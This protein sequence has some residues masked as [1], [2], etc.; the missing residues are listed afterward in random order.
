MQTFFWIFFATIL[1]SLAA[2]VGIFTLSLKQKFLDKILLRLVALSSGAMLGGAFIYLLPEGVGT[3]EPKVFSLF[4]LAA[5]ILYFLIE[6]ILHW[7]HCHNGKHCAV[8]SFGYLN[9][10]GGAV[11][12]FIDGLIIAAA[13]LI[14]LPLG[15]TTTLAIALHVIP[16]EIGNFAILLYAGLNKRKA[17]Y[18]NFLASATIILGGITGL[19]LSSQVS[20]F[21]KFLLPIAVGGFI[22]IALSDLIPE[23][24]KESDIRNFLINF[25]LLLL[26][27]ALM[28]II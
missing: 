26:G 3:M 18:I 28:Y 24:R 27:V 7:R 5:L 12:K 14:S 15:L 8:H 10:I 19:A 23:L 25:G 2:L 9:L 13:F 21:T 1:I 6:K 16:Q 20:G 11:H 17:L 4:V 22:Y